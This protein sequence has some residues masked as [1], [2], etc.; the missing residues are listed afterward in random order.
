MCM[1][2]YMRGRFDV[3]YTI[4]FFEFYSSFYTVND[5]LLE[6]MSILFYLE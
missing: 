6:L 5:L 3:L 2:V 4:Q 1:C